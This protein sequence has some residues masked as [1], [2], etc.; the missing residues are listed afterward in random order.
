MDTTAAVA[1]RK[2]SAFPAWH[3]AILLTALAVLVAMGTRPHG[4]SPNH[5]LIGYLIAATFEWA[6][7]AW[8]VFGCR[9]KG[10]SL[11]SLLGEFSA[12]WRTIL[13]DVG[14]AIAYLVLANIVLSILGHFLAGPPNEALK[15]ILPHTPV[16]QAVFV[17]LAATA[18]FCEELIYRG[19]LQRQFAAWTGSLSIALVLQG[20]VFGASHAYQGFGQVL[21]ITV[22]GCMYGLLAAWR[23]SL[24]PGMIAH[25]LQDAIS[26]LLLARSVLK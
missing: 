8:I 24:R 13:R 26:G 11:F 25:F 17:G 4:K 12:C 18:G 20:I 10:Q 1:D 6:M 5:R 14:L 15:D 21:I 9:L 7:V 22:Y 3:T 19:Y 23:K 2:I 16:E